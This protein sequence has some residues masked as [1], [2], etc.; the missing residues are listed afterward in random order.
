MLL[1][2]VCGIQCY[3][4][5][6]VPVPPTAEELDTLAP[7]TLTN[8]QRTRYEVTATAVVESLILGL[9]G[10]LA[11]LRAV[12]VIKTLLLSD[13]EK[14]YKIRNECRDTQECQ[15]PSECTIR[16]R[17]ICM[18]TTF[19]SNLEMTGEW[20]WQGYFTVQILDT[21]LQIVRLLEQ[22]GRSI[23]GQQTP[24][25]DRV[26]IMTQATLIMLVMLVGPTTLILNNR[27]WASLFDVMA[28]FSFTAA[29]L[30]IS[31]HIIQVGTWHTLQFTTF[32]TF[33]SSLVPAVL[34]L[35]NIVGVDR[36]LLEIAKRPELT[37]APRRSRLRCYIIAFT[38]WVVGLGGFIYVTMTQFKGDYCSEVIPRF[39]KECLLPIYPILDSDSC[40]CRM[41]SVYLQEECVQDDMPRLSLYNRM[42]YL[43]ISDN[44][45]TPPTSCT[46]EPQTLLDTVSKFGSLVVL[47]LV[48][49]PLQTL[50]LGKLNSLEVLVATAT[51]LSIVPDDVNELLPSIRSF[52]F[53][54][55]QI[56][57]LPFDSLQQLQHLEYLGLAGNPICQSAAFPEWTV[58]IV[59]CG[60]SSGDACP[61]ESSLVGLSQS[62][63]GYCRK[64]VLRGASTLCLPACTDFYAPTYAAMDMDGSTTM[65]V[66]ENTVLFQMFGL[67]EPG[68]EVTTTVHHCIMEACGKEASDEI[69]AP[70]EAVVRPIL[71]RT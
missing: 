18:F 7:E 19:R 8:P 70:V 43:M 16:R 27:V 56:Q 35:D 9:I 38:M 39:D 2:F 47:S 53:E 13:K 14:L 33:L 21:I 48:A 32:T 62:L 25:A 17:I 6:I 42:E 52:Q 59:E 28:A 36:Y 22:G 67:I 40:D 49:V 69:T 24:V 65:S 45:P 4:Q 64:W 20:F 30:I 1:A 41:A 50:S 37:R 15:N 34:S 63:T 23:T 10:L 12:V 57:E 61:V 11:L 58:G 46:N 68:I 60:S 3:A 66:Q 5:F 26:A 51:R 29:Y 44:T 31:G 71:L 54:L 55:S